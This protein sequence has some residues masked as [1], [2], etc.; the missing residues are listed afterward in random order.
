MADHG[1]N[2]SASDCCMFVRKFYDGNFTI[3]VLY[4]DEM[5]IICH[6][7]QKIESLKTDLS[8]YFTMRNTRD[9]KNG[10]LWLSQ[11]RYIEKVL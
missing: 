5:L 6:D 1:Y 4:V 11:Q 3:L 2:K 8:K 7:I 10:K 9:K